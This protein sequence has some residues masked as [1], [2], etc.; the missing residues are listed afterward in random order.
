M[1]PSL[2]L[3]TKKI[4]VTG[5]FGAL[6]SVVSATLRSAGAEVACVDTLPALKAPAA[7]AGCTVIG[8]ADLSSPTGAKTAIDEAARKLGGIDGLV[9]IAGGFRWEKIADGNVATWDLMFEI[10]V[11]TTL[12][13]IQAA[14]P[15]L[16][17]LEGRIV[18][19]GAASAMKAGLGMA[20]YAASK[21]GVAKITESLAEELKDRHIT[22][23]A[24]LP[25]VIDTPAN[26]ADMPTA[27]FDRWVRPEQI[28][29]AIAFLLSPHASAITGAL[30]PITG[31]V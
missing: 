19:I 25:S 7:I 21:A 28:A 18:N 14:L 5:A 17:A 6:G 4:V 31:R 24:L 13:S 23:N 20:P 16:C 3:S 10:N 30:I 29:D 12:N 11:R 22:V 9:N 27:E 8:E 1:R 26:R 15:H 2:N